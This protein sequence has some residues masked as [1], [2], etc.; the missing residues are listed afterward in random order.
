MTV[1]SPPTATSHASDDR[2][3]SIA[4]IAPADRMTAMTAASSGLLCLTAPDMPSPT[5]VHN[6]EIRD[7]RDDERGAI[8]ELTLRAYAEYTTIM[9]PVTWAGLE[10]AIHAALASD[11]PVERI[12]ADDHG[13]LIGSV[14]LYPPATKAY[15]NM[16]A[17]LSW[18]EV[19]L[20]SVAPESRGRGVARALMDECL[21]RARRTGATA[22]GLHTSRSMRAAT[23]MYTRMGFVRVP[24]FDHQPPGAELV[25]AYRLAL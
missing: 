21:R 19:R 25:E 15:G 3:E 16:L 13:T 2:P 5:A 23:A 11:A 20:V 4:N 9:E 1:V 8:R 22:I 14:M 6:F 24:E 7:A 17:E 18:P 12:V 10:Q